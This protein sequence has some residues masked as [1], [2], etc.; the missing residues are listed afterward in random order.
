MAEGV[1]KE[2]QPPIIRP[3]D[4]LLL[5]KYF[6]LIIHSMQSLSVII[7]AFEKAW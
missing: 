3:A 7:S 4:Q 1:W 6:D 5:N 2:V